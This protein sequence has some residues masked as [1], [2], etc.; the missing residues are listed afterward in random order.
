MK[1]TDESANS[2][3]I[4]ELQFD[5]P[6]D[7]TR[8]ADDTAPGSL[9][10]DPVR[11]RLT[12]TSIDSD[13]NKRWWHSQF[14]L[15]LAVFG[16]LVVTALLFVLLAPPPD[17]QQPQYVTAPAAATPIAD[18]E[19][20]W[21]QSQLAEARTESQDILA[22]LLDSKKSLEEKDVLLWAPDRYQDALDVAAAGDEHYKQQEFALAIATY[23]SAADQMESLFDLLP[24]LI[25]TRLEEGDAAIE[26]GKSALAKEKYENV[27]LL[28]KD[29]LRA[30]AGLDRAS[31]LDQVLALIANAAGEE[32]DFVES[33]QIADLESAE[34]YLL[35]A[36]TID[37][38]YQAIDEG[39]ASVRQAIVDRRFQLEMSKAYQAL[40]ANRYSAARNAFS[41]AL[42]IKPGDKSAAAAL[43]QS[44]ASDKTATL[45]SLL[46]NAKRFENQEEWASAQSNYQTVLQRDPNQVG[47]KLGNIRTGARN[48]LDLRIREVL[49]DT[50]GLGRSE[51]KARA[52]SVLKDARGIKSKGPKLRQQI[53]QLEAA[54]QQSDTL[55]R[56]SFISDSLT[57]VSLK[58]AGSK[59]IKLGQFAQRNMA[60]KPGRYTATGVRLGYQDVRNEIELLPS[61]DEVQPITIKC[62]QPIT[63]SAVNENANG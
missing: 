22:N 7:P 62:D 21:T 26:A 59:P 4:E 55:V 12:G 52:D 39:L 23:Q 54:L 47:A 10:K 36:K 49:A 33:G 50:L 24:A 2:Q 6:G 44:L 32:A 29:N 45:S 20:P 25:N 38:N 37:E 51:N 17:I 41:A 18:S 35:Q 27:L 16:L 8:P 58:K 15:M 42:K 63:A 30:T 5:V 3:S 14:N 57:E 19:T 46:A 1:P 40:F 60:L 48:Q 31:K 43:Q 9:P 61:G 53:A 28:E 34:Q 11:A 13:S 56:V